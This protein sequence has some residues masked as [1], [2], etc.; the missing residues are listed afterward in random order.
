[1]AMNN[2]KLAQKRHKKNL[3]RKNKKY[4]PKQ[5]FQVRDGNLVETTPPPPKPLIADTETITF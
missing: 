2:N 3:K 1:M 5:Y 4:T